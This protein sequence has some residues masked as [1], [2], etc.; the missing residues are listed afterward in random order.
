MFSSGA[1]LFCGRFS[2]RNFRSRL[3]EHSCLNQRLSKRNCY[4]GMYCHFLEVI[5]LPMAGNQLYLL[6]RIRQPKV[7]KLL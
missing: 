2:S 7:S 3:A 6:N 1:F 5:L 4:S